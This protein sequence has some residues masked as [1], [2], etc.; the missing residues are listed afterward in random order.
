MQ[1]PISEG[2]LHA[3]DIEDL[4]GLAHWPGTM[5]G[6]HQVAILLWLNQIR[7]AQEPVGEG[8][9]RAADTALKKRK[10][11]KARRGGQAPPAAPTPVGDATA[12][13][14]NPFAGISLTP[15]AQAANPFAGVSLAA[16][17]APEVSCPAQSL[18]A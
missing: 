11:F 2:F 13:G 4:Q 9:A 10:I 3:D 18:T 14:A 17:E 15:A 6:N 16:P 12:T 5:C 8:F 7:A 1:E